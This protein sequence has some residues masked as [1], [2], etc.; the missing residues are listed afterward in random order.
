VRMACCVDGGSVWFCAVAVRA[1]LKLN[2]ERERIAT[3]LRME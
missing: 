3:G 1:R 2:A